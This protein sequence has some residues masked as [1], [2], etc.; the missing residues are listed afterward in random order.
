MGGP[1]VLERAEYWKQ[2]WVYWEY[3]NF[4]KTWGSSHKDK[5]AKRLHEILIP[6]PNDAVN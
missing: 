1:E 4:G 6:N 2:G 5:S 3:K